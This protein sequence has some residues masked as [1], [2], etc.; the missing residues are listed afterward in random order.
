MVSKSDLCHFQRSTYNILLEK[1]SFCSC[2]FHCNIALPSKGE[3]FK[4]LGYRTY[5]VW[6]N[7]NNFF[8][9]KVMKHCNIVAYGAHVGRTEINTN[10]TSS[11]SLWLCLSQDSQRFR[12]FTQFY[13]MSKILIFR[14]N[15]VPRHYWGMYKVI[16][17]LLV[18]ETSAVDRCEKSS[19][20][21]NNWLCGDNVETRVAT[22]NH[23]HG[24]RY[25]QIVFL[26]AVS[27]A[28][29]KRFSHIEI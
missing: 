20:W 28:R 15:T 29:Y 6:F 18:L 25:T 14:S 4:A 12:K 22:I 2:Y 19:S 3:L 24:G 7:I 9:P 17:G 11:L 8:S 10:V 13:K 5:H 16:P 26:S 23:M 1:H 21:A 27:L